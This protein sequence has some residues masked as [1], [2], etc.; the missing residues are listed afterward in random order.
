MEDKDSRIEGKGSQMEVKEIKQ[1]FFAR[2]NGVTADV[3]KRGGSGFEM[4]FGVDVPSISALSKEIGFDK[5]LA[6]RLWADRKVR[7][8]HLL[9]AWLLDPVSLSVEECVTLA[10]SVV[11]MEDAQMLAF[12]VLKHRPEVLARLAPESMAA[13]AMRA[14]ME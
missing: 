5:E 7:E 9:A 8:S 14:H 12:R 3:L 6:I 4:I 1:Y 11:D 10:D 13:K 2:R